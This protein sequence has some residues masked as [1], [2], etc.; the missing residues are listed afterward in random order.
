M[1]GIEI[2]KNL[3]TKI[4]DSNVR[5]KIEQLLKNKSGDICFLCGQ[6]FNYATDVIHADHDIPEANGGQTDFDN[7]NLSHKECNKFKKDHPTL[8]VKNFL[9]FKIFIDKNPTAKFSEACKNYFKFDPSPI[10]INSI[11]GNTCTIHFPDGTVGDNL[12][13]LT[14]SRPG[15]RTYKYIYTQV[16]VKSIFNDDVQPRAIKYGHV[17]KIFNDLHLNPLHEPCSV[18]LLAEFKEGPNEFR[19]FDGQHKAISKMLLNNGAEA[20][21]DVKI[22]LDL[23]KDEAVILVNSIQSKIIKLGLTKSEFAAK[24]RDEFKEEFEKYEENCKSIGSEPS[25]EGFVKSATSDT[26]KSR[27]KE[28]LLQARIDQFM[29]LSKDELHILKI[30]ENK[31]DL[32]DSK[33]MIMET[34]FINKLL[35]SLMYFKPMTSPIKED[36]ARNSERENVKYILN[37][38]FLEGLD[39]DFS[40]SSESDLYKMKNLKAQ[41]S[42]TLFSFFAKKIA[43]RE[44][45]ASNEEIFM[46]QGLFSDPVKNRLKDAAKRYV[47]HPIWVQNPKLN[48]NLK[49]VEFFN[50]L[51]KNGT[52]TEIAG[53]I[54]LSLEYLTGYKDLDGS[55]FE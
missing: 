9:P 55:E 7:L 42:L 49:V 34:T 20:R 47:S 26:N 3:K 32:T 22:Y 13:I 41:S 14:E 39:L 2:S 36:E 19:M 50:T 8:N 23:S 27:R 35:K 45:F 52:L 38:F 31:T 17:Y 53:K 15:G 29:S 18:R 40:N 16:P 54:D 44:M 4:V 51:Q 5:D 33:L 37:Q 30:V 28:A 43:S 46:T 6:P 48:T 10:N 11:V 24:M 21:I 1:A 12:E 25:E